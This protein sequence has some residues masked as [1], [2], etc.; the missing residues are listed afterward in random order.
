M[1]VFKHLMALA[2]IAVGFLGLFFIIFAVTRPAMHNSSGSRSDA[3][4]RELEEKIRV[5]EELKLSNSESGKTMSDEKAASITIA[6]E[7]VRLN[8]PGSSPIVSSHERFA[9]AIAGAALPETAVLYVDRSIAFD[10]VVHVID[11]VKQLKP[12]IVIRIATAQNK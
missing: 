12:G 3:Q 7:H 6:R 8:L 11:R 10:R 9:D 2:D 4:I 5:L 1:R